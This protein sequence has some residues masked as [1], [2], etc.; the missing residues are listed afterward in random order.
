[1]AGRFNISVPGRRGP[2]DPWFRIGTVDVNT[3]LLVILIEV[4]GL[5]VYAVQKTALES[6]M[7]FSSDTRGY[8]D[9]GTFRDGQVWRALTWPIPNDPSIWLVFMLAIFWYFG[10]EVERLL[11]RTRFAA[12]LLTIIVIPGV[13]AG[14]LDLAPVPL[15]IYDF[16]AV[17]L[18]VFLVF[19]AE[20]PF[21]RFFFG[22]PAWAIGA[23]IVGIEFIQLIGD[24]QER[25]LLFRLI[26]FAVAALAARSLG[27]LSNLPWIP[28]IPLGRFGSGAPRRRKPKRAR[29]SGR[30]GRSSGGGDVV[31]GPWSAP[32]SGPVSSAPLPQPPVSDV[33]MAADQAE[34]DALLDKISD[35]G[36]DGLSSGEK[37]RL[38]ELSKR[39]RNRR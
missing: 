31:A 4:V 10:N 18:C 27:L 30:S 6:L 29:P 24:R 16:R 35:A 2:S 34:L 38:N 14:L 25:A 5:I 26:G 11:G 21:A 19:I 7:L 28:A 22:I 33:D 1:M 12:F 15:A 36:M 9:V 13:L 8:R 39:M 37:Q 17:E 3:T 23:I 20:Y 32:R